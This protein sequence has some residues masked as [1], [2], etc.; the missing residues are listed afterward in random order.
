M[1]LSIYRDGDAVLGSRGWPINPADA[2]ESRIHAAVKHTAAGISG[3]ALREYLAGHG[4]AAYIFRAT[5]E[6]LRHHLAKGR[7]IVVCLA[8]RGANAPLHYVV[9]AGLADDAVLVNDPTRG[10]LLREDLSSFTKAWESTGNWSLLAV[11]AAA[12]Q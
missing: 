8:P 11:P 6:D 3:Q 4:F 9:V 10:K 12:Q 1:R 7:P 5:T 2:D